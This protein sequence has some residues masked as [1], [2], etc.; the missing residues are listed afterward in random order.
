MVAKNKKEQEKSTS[1]F[2]KQ[3]RKDNAKKLNDANLFRISQTEQKLRKDNINEEQK[4]NQTHYDVGKKIR[5][6]IEDI[7]GAMPEDLPTPNKSLKA[8][9]KENKRLEIK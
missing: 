7:G 5:K 1:S 8:L 9:E 2:G 4:A 3:M 6:T